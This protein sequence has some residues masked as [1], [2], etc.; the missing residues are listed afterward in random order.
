[1]RPLLTAILLAGMLL[2]P[3]VA[4]ADGGAQKLL[5]DA[6]RDEK[7]DGTYTQAEY[8]KA[9]DQLPADSDEYTACR[10]VIQDARL[11]A[12]SNRGAKRGSGHPG[13]GAGPTSSGG[14]G[15]GAAAGTA[16][17]RSDP[18]AKAS[19]SERKAIEK[20]ASS[21]APVA[22]AG[23]LVRPGALGL[24]SLSGSDRGLPT[25]LVAVIVLLA[26]AALGAGG[27]WLWTGVL[28]RRLR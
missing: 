8:K 15:S 1:M 28:A 17:P 14:G 12:L 6:C 10:Q 13:A 18:L 16:S 11:A 5:I 25:T 7:V 26:L 27:H 24:G 9:L 2:V 4:R 21:G 20:A 3:S 23:K 19:P 22:I